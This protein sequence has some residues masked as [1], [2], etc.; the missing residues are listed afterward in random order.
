MSKQGRKMTTDEKIAYLQSL[1]NKA[2]VYEREVLQR[3]LDGKKPGKHGE[4][5]DKNSDETWGK[6]AN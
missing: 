4:N 1:G 6:Y 2:S 3:L 5:S